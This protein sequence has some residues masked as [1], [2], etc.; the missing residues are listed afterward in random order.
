MIHSTV[1]VRVRYAET[2]KMGVVYHGN[3]AT[4]CETARIEFFRNLGLPY[5]ELED[6]GVML[7]V[8]ELEMKFHKPAYF[9]QLLSIYIELEEI[10]K[11][12]RIIFNYKIKNP[13]AELL[14][15][16]RSVLA[17]IDM[18]TNR[19]TRAPEYMIKR[20]EEIESKQKNKEI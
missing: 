11:G 7:P 3:Y 14:T 9:D 4:F 5:K 8:T 12:A 20:L 15:T 1:T 13:K 18:K 19:P 10:P 16:A 17:F 6:R 2:D